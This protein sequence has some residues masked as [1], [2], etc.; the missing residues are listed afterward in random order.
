M[1]I[2]RVPSMCR[3]AAVRR[4]LP[5]TTLSTRASTSLSEEMCSSSNNNNNNIAYNFTTTPRRLGWHQSTFLFAALRNREPVGQR[6][7][8]IC[9]TKFIC[10]LT[11]G[12]SLPIVVRLVSYSN[13]TKNFVFWIDSVPCLS[14]CLLTELQLGLLDDSIGKLTSAPWQASE[15]PYRSLVYNW[16][17]QL[18]YQ[19]LELTRTQVLLTRSF[20]SLCFCVVLLLS[21][22]S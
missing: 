15:E 4:D 9:T 17:S 10:Y 12:Q 22:A 20:A 18:I 14:R 3:T 8:S 16:T 13:G 21:A 11:V 5:L 19:I 6:C 1:L 2:P 7:S